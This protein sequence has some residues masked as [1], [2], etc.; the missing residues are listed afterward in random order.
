MYKVIIT[1][2]GTV[3]EFTDRKEAKAFAKAQRKQGNYCFL[4]Y[5]K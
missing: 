4:Q 2:A 1:S 3:Y 5:P